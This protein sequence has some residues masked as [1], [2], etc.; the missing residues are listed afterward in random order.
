LVERSKQLWEYLSFRHSAAPDARSKGS[1]TSPWGAARHRP[2]GIRCEW[3][4]VYFTVVSKLVDVVTDRW[5]ENIHRT[6]STLHWM[7]R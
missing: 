5:T 1:F 4:S 3:T 6:E 2:D 7:Q